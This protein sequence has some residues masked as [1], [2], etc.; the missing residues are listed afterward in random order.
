METAQ[1]SPQNLPPSDLLAALKRS[2]ERNRELEAFIHWE[3]ELF[4]NP[5]LSG[6]HKLT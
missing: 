2:Q 4:T 5:H 6:N 3:D 1:T